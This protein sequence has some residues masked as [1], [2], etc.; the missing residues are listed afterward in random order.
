MLRDYDAARS[1]AKIRESVAFKVP[2]YIAKK[3]LN[4]TATLYD[5]PDGSCMLIKAATSCADCWHPD[6]KGRADDIHLGPIKGAP[7]RINR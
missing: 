6:W 5:F 1:Y 2:G 4:G 3:K 7:L